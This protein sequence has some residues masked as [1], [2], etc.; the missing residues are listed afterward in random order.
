MTF[1]RL[2]MEMGDIPYTEAGQAD[3][4]IYKPKYDSQESV[5]IAILNELKEAEQLFAKGV[6]FAGDPTPYGGDPVKWR[7]A[8]NALSLKILMSLSKK[9]DVASLN[10]KQRFA[11]IV[12]G[13]FLLENSTTSYFGL[14]YSVQNKH[15]LNGTSDMFTKNT[16]MSSLLVDSLKAFNDRRIYYYAEPSAAKVA[17]G[18]NQTNL[19][20]YVGA[21]VAMDY[22]T[23]TADHNVKKYSIINKRYLA[24]VASDPR[25]LLSFAEQQLIL[26]EARVLGWISTKTAKT[27]YEEGVKSA[28][29]TIM[30][31]KSSYAHNKAIDQAYINSYFTGNAAF[32]A[33]PAEQL[34]QIWMQRY[35]LNY[36]QDCE[37]S[38]FEYRRTAFPPFPINAS[39]NLNQNNKNGIPMRWLYPGSETDYNRTNLTNALNAQYE[40]YD[41]VNKLMWILK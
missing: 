10:A 26:A 30:A 11:D 33:N 20:A 29:A 38:Y 7:R 28:L 37:T 23:L 6:K 34:K 21:D 35:F 9:A 13:D 24:E 41:E 15:P 40:G 14:I 2:T 27:Y 19:D 36:M 17:S 1:Y 22:S 32:K 18:V 16:V 8:T 5:L 31:T 39:T 4:G 3:K 12:A 25:I